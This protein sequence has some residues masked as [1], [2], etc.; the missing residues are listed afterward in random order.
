VAFWRRFGCIGGIASQ[1]GKATKRSRFGNSTSDQIAKTEKATDFCISKRLDFHFIDAEWKDN[2]MAASEL[3][4]LLTYCEEQDADLT[5]VLTVNA[6]H[7]DAFEILGEYLEVSSQHSNA[8]FCFVAGNP[9]YLSEEERQL[10][11]KSRMCG[12]VTCARRTLKSAPIF[13]GSEGQLELAMELAEKHTAIP[14][15]LL[16]SSVHDLAARLLSSDVC[17]G[18]GVY[19]PYLFSEIDDQDLQIRTLGLYALRRRWVR[20]AL[21]NVGVTPSAVRSQISEKRELDKRARQVLIDAI[22]TLSLC[23]V[24]GFQGALR[25]FS[26]IGVRYLA[27]LSAL[28]DFDGDERFYEILSEV[29]KTT[30]L[31]DRG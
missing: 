15:M 23:D 30:S 24:E 6:R 16:G 8:G 28:E 9:I 12:L 31:R 5:T 20:Q 7:S 29:R 1:I 26:S 3:D 17:D 18:I 27:F 19:C 4:R 21:R 10:D 2:Y 22:R 11:T 25:K 13:I 14:F